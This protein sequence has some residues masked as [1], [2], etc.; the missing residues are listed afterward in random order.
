MTSSTDTEHRWLLLLHYL[1]TIA[2]IFR[3]VSNGTMFVAHK[4]WEI[5][6]N[7]TNFIVS[8]VVSDTSHWTTRSCEIQTLYVSFKDLEWQVSVMDWWKLK[9]QIRI[10][11]CRTYAAKDLAWSLSPHITSRIDGPTIFSE[12]PSRK[13]PRIEFMACDS[14]GLSS[15]TIMW[16]RRMVWSKLCGKPDFKLM[17]PLLLSYQFWS[18]NF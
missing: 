15:M 12:I 14:R 18:M 17:L 1:M 7:T 10:A 16:Y 11:K 4:Y 2:L 5:P 6:T 9:Y 13:K 3:I 8:Y